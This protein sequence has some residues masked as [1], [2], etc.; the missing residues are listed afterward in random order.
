MIEKFCA[1]A[2]LPAVPEALPVTLPVNPTDEC[3]LLLTVNL[4]FE[5]SQVN[6][7]LLD[8]APNVIPA[9][10]VAANELAPEPTVIFKSST[11]SVAVFKV[12]V[13][14]C[15]IKSPVTVKSFPIVTSFGNPTVTVPAFSAT[16]TSDEV[17]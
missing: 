14:P 9:P 11:S 17:P 4:V 2:K 7:G 8:D 13:S 10:F 5:L 1:L 3:N 15:T 16:V 6:V 12:V